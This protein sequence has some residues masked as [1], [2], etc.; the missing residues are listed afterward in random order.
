M[1]DI[2]SLLDRFRRAGGAPGAPAPAG[3]VP[4]DPEAQLR[5][6]LRLLL[7]ALEDIEDEADAVRA[8]GEADASSALMAADGEAERIATTA[9][10]EAARV[11]REATAT[12]R[13]SDRDK[14][15]AIVAAAAVEAARVR[16]RARRRTDRLVAKVMDCAWALAQPIEVGRDVAGVD[17][18]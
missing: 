6:E 7:L 17:G 2:R 18:S 11:R 12:E 3:A 9:R 5:A 15:Q 14:A 4:P 16:R 8:A 10:V 13:A 1:V